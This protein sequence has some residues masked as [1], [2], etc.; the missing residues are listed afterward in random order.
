MGWHLVDTLAFES[1][2]A[3]SLIRT[4]GLVDLV[5]PA[6]AESHGHDY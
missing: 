4:T 5:E 3:V 1:A 2:G 6:P